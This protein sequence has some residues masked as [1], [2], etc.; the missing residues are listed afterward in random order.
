MTKT[1]VQLIDRICPNAAKQRSFIYGHKWIGRDKFYNHVLINALSSLPGGCI[2]T[3]KR[4]WGGLEEAFLWT[5]GPYR[6]KL[7]FILLKSAVRHSQ[8]S[9]R[10]PHGLKNRRASDAHSVNVH[11]KDMDRRLICEPVCKPL[12]GPRP[13]ILDLTTSTVEANS[14]RHPQGDTAI[15]TI[16]KYLCRCSMVKQRNV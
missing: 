4:P 7:T 12:Y 6:I 15:A 9:V 14:L 2:A 1:S 10:T 8:G 11:R 13:L 16:R 3:L 5:H